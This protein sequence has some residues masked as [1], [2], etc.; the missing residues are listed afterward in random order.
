MYAEKI[1]KTAPSKEP[2]SSQ[3][4][5]NELVW[6]QLE[7]MGTSKSSFSM[8]QCGIGVY[9]SLSFDVAKEGEVNVG[10]GDMKIP[11]GLFDG[12]VVP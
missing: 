8:I 1:P 3:I 10:V 12:V 11:T 5:V 7:E 2:A 9:E 6:Y 4:F